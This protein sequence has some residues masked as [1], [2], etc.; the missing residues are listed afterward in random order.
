MPHDRDE[1]PAPA[2]EGAPAF[3]FNKLPRQRSKLFPAPD[4]PPREPAPQE[5]TPTL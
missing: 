5:R 4:D 1:K 2:P 3:D